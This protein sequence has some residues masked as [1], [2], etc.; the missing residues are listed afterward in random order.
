MPDRS[1]LL[2]QGRDNLLTAVSRRW[3]LTSCIVVLGTGIAGLCGLSRKPSFTATA[4]IMLDREITRPFG[5]GQLTTARDLALTGT[6]TQARFIESDEVLGIVADRLQL[7]QRQSADAAEAEDLQGWAEQVWHFMPTHLLM[8]AVGVASEPPNPGVQATTEPRAAMVSR[9]RRRVVVS[10]EEDTRV[11]EIS[12]RSPNPEMA[13]E[14]V[15]EIAETYLRRRI[16]YQL[17]PVERR[18]R[19]LDERL[20]RLREQA[21]Q[22]EQKMLDYRRQHPEVHLGHQILDMRQFTVELELFTQARAQRQDAEVRLDLVAELSSEAVDATSEVI[23]SEGLHRLWLEQQQLADQRTALSI[24]L[25]VK[26]PETM[27]LAARQAELQRKGEAERRRIIANLAAEVELLKVRQASAEGGLAVL[28]ENVNASARAALRLDQLRREA[29][30]D[31]DLYERLLLQRIKL[32]EEALFEP[33]AGAAIIQR[34][35]VPRAP[36]SRSTGQFILVGFLASSIVASS[37]AWLFQRNRR[38]FESSG[39]VERYLGLPCIGNLAEAEPAQGCRDAKRLDLRTKD[40]RYTDS[41]L[42]LARRLSMLDV[43]RSLQIVHVTSTLPEEGKTTTAIGLAAILASEGARVVLVDL[44]LRRPQVGARLRQ[45]GGRLLPYLLG[46]ATDTLPTT[47]SGTPRLDIVMAD[48]AIAHPGAVLQSD[49]LRRLVTDLRATYDF[50]VMDSPPA[51]GMTDA[52][53]VAALADITLFL[54]RYRMTDQ[55]AAVEALAALRRQNTKLG[56]VVM[57]RGPAAKRR[58][59]SPNRWPRR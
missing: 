52:A 40:Q 28:I 50:V 36:S 12:L 48:K 59:T 22:A 17:S 42:L 37:L 26:H 44:D 49:R 57:T 4:M 55:A 14:I 10:R 58:P 24:A 19:W 25:G 33:D 23:A 31:R 30:A 1:G 45:S 51:L 27:A 18:A 39:E 38:G 47:W 43:D 53:S 11:L 21:V 34:A 5:R 35:T 8:A 6:N 2:P 20:T 41:V 56:A 3:L 15:N 32:R 54:V 29:E 7:H 46:E 13:A 16:A 9:L